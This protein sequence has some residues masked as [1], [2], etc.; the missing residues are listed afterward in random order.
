MA[1]KT[2]PKRGPVRRYV[3]ATSYRRGLLGGNRRWFAVWAVLAV[4]Q[5]LRKHLGRT[6]EVVYRTELHPGE[7][8]HILHG[9]PAPREL[10]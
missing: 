9:T 5:F 2:K 7:E 6:E 4:T 1:K 3:Q 10:A 8:L